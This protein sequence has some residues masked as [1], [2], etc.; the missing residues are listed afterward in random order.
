[1]EDIMDTADNPQRSANYRN[2]HR[3]VL[4]AAGRNI[5]KIGHMANDQRI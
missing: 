1:M 2:I 4:A 3:E 5:C